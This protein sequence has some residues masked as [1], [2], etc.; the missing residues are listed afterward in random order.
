VRGWSLNASAA[1]MNAKVS[2]GTTNSSATSNQNNAAMSF[3]P[4]KTMSLWSTYQLPAGFTI[5][6]GV[7]YVDT[8]ARTAST[9]I[10]GATNTPYAQ[11]YWIADAMAAYQI[12]KNASI[13]LNLYNLNNARYTASLNNSGT[14]YIPGVERSAKLSLNL[15]Y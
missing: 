1:L 3:S 10:N 2:E 14:R 6:G 4:K 9:T 13:Q 11:S 7:R 12:D 8:M 5:G 15:A